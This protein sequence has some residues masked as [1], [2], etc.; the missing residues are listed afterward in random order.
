MQRQGDFAKQRPQIQVK[1][2]CFSLT[3][4][5]IYYQN[6]KHHLIFK[7]VPVLG[8]SLFPLPISEALLSNTIVRCYLSPPPHDHLEN[9]VLDLSQSIILS[10][11]WNTLGSL[12]IMGRKSFTMSTT[13]SNS[14]LEGRISG[15]EFILTPLLEVTNYQF[16]HPVLFPNLINLTI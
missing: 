12:C 13:D 16:E 6:L 1:T 7:K 10:A 11:G 14:H 2:L 15:K 8:S 9:P 5:W 4:I 3:V